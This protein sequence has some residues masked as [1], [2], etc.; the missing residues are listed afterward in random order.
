MRPSL[1]PILPLALLACRSVPQRS[2]AASGPAPIY[3]V[4]ISPSRSAYPTRRSDPGLLELRAMDLVELAGFAYM[5]VHPRVECSFPPS[6]QRYDVSVRMPADLR[7]PRP[8]RGAVRDAIE[9][10]FGL[11]AAPVKRPMD[12]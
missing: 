3:E 8:A 4:S 12:V 2:P 6:D 10:T 9:R 5:D 7:D 1:L 11:K